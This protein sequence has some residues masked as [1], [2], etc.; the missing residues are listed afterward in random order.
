MSLSLE[1]SEYISSALLQEQLSWEL[2]SSQLLRD[3]EVDLKTTS[4]RPLHSQIL[5]LT[6]MTRRRME[7]E[8][9]SKKVL[10]ID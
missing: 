7:K 3:L 5:I 1:L 9:S 4:M 10:E 6:R 8:A 2:P